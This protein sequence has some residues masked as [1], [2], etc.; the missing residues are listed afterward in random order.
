MEEWLRAGLVAKKHRGEVKNCPTAGRYQ[1][2]VWFSHH[3]QIVN[4]LWIKSFE[5][6][7]TVIY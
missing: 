2:N 4:N 1:M 7:F 3:P 5:N 6:Y